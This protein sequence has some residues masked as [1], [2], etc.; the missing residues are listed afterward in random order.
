MEKIIRK[1]EAVF[2][3]TEEDM[4]R[5]ILKLLEA[6]ADTTTAAIAGKDG[7]DRRSGQKRNR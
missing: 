2:M 1:I 3:K 7:T 5:E 6:D 4:K